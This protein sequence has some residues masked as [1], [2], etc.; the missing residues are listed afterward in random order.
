MW[1]L[2]PREHVLLNRAQQERRYDDYELASVIAVMHEAAHRAKRP[3]A[4]DL[5][6]RPADGVTEDKIRK[7]AE[8]AKHAEEWLSQFKF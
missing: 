5:F 2:T 8:K 6:K 1:A 4:S 7:Q 3:K